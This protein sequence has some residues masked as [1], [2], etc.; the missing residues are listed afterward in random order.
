[1]AEHAKSRILHVLEWK[2]I[3]KCAFYSSTKI[4]ALT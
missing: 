3:Q 1:M 2:Q 4:D